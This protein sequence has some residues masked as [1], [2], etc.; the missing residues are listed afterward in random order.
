MIRVY[1]IDDDQIFLTTLKGYLKDY[2]IQTDQEGRNALEDIRQFQPNVIL[3][4]INL[5]GTSGFEICRAIRA[6]EQ[7]KHIPVL[8]ISAEQDLETKIKSIEVGAEDFLV[9]PIQF[10]LLSAKI[11]LL[12]Y[13]FEQLQSYRADQTSAQEIA[14]EAMR[15]SSELG[16]A[17]LFVER[18]QQIDNEQGLAQELVNFCHYLNLHVVVGIKLQHGWLCTSS[19]GVA[20]PIEQDVIVSAHERGRFVDF[21]ARTQ[22][23]YQQIALLIKNMPVNEPERYGRIKDT[24]PPVLSAFDVRLINLRESQAILTQTLLMNRSIETVQPILDTLAQRIGHLTRANKET[25]TNLL[26]EMSLRLPKLGL[27]DDQEEFIMAALETS[28]EIASDLCDEGEQ[29]KQHMEK[30]T[31]VLQGIMARQKQLSDAVLDKQHQASEISSSDDGTFAS[32]VE[33]F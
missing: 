4:D 26:E 9:K 3:L 28:S 15:S 33:L 10:E 12:H 20:T 13:N 16:Q 6:D 22:I 19:Q 8:F 7:L 5:P 29:I 31:L 1:V 23:N 21:G 17:M 25:A 27:D 18:C 11:R 32:D 14:I 2:D 30:I 24:L